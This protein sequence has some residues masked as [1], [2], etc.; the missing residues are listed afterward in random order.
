VRTSESSSGHTIN[1]D[2]RLSIWNRARWLWVN[3]LNNTRAAS[4]L[5]PSLILAAF[6]AGSN[7]SDWPKIDPKASPSRR[8]CDLFW[9]ALPW[10]RIA[11][12]LGNAVQVLEIGCGTGRYGV[13]A[14]ECLDGAFAGYLGMDAV[15]HAE[16]DDHRSNPKFEFVCADSDTTYQYLSRANLIITQSALEHFERDLAFFRQLADHAASANRQML[17]IHLM[18]SAACITTFPWHG[19]RQY[20]P[21]TVSR[22]TRMFGAETQRRLYSLGSSACNRVHRRYIT[23]PWLLGKDDQ[24][25][26]RPA[27]YDRDLREAVR[28]DDA[29]PT[30]G[31][32]CF[33]ALVLQ[34]HLARDIFHEPR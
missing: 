2:R 11:A 10:P 29:A 3:W 13:L 14:E 24:R 27:D 26:R 15:R 32:A 5:D 30:G 22:I 23:Y 28:L 18:P 9:R 17:Q 25:A 16:W 20:T 6:I 7:P 19:V 21:R 33:H 31:V 8:L 12:H 1:G 34:S 4:N